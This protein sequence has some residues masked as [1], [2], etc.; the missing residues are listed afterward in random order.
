[1]KKVG[2]IGAGYWG[3]NLIR[4]LYYFE[5]L[6]AICDIDRQTLD[7][8]S[9]QYAGR[10]FVNKIDYLWEHVDAVVIATPAAT[11][12]QIAKEA[13]LRGKDI[14]IEKPIALKLEDGQELVKLARQEESIL[15]V[16]HILEYHPTIKW[17]KHLISTEDL[18]DIH[19]IYSHRLN[20]GKIRREENVMWSFAPHD[21]AV[22]L[23][24][25]DQMPNRVFC[26][27][28][29]Y[30]A[31]GIVDTTISYLY[32]PNGV[33]AHIFVSWLHPYKEQRL[34]VV[35]SKKMAVFDGSK[36][37]ELCLYAHNA[38]TINPSNLNVGKS[39]I[40]LENKEPLREECQH[41]L[42]CIDEQRQ[43]L[44]DGESALRVL[45][46]LEA[47]QRSLETGKIV[48]LPISISAIN[49]CLISSKMLKILETGQRSLEG[50]CTNKY[51]AAPTAI[52][53]AGA[54]IGRETKIWHYSH[55][56]TRAK[57]G[58]YCNIGKYV[59]IENG[60]IVGNNV[61]IQ[62]G[63]SVYSGVMLEDNVFVGPNVVFTNVRR[64]R[65][66]FPAF[67][68]ENTTIKKG[69]TIGA[70]ATIRCGVTIGEYA[71]VAA[72]AVVTKDV[73]PYKLVM[74]NPARIIS[75]VNKCGGVD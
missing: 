13:L 27:G 61:K 30:L 2:V 3:K 24:L 62:N 23:R 73:P 52:I 53:E 47:C 21:I 28:G 33:Q 12:F 36:Q 20:L 35:G 19:Y 54:E 29:N 68:Y 37:D 10:I 44:T 46:V 60:A 63:V 50:N 43:P 59:S 66:E 48:E 16:G 8:M 31:S 25:L 72:G 9:T 49:P 69:A 42:K 15:M 41:F 6:D 74:G 71:F 1:M 18:G 58:A 11:H 4:E 32:F 45:A 39:V 56:M 67:G 7:K 75:T 64:P 55:V 65:S 22:I 5:R 38:H 70:N 26:G 57:I 40:Y 14:F 17:L 51:F 34:V